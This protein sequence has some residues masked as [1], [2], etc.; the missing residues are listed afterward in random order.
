MRGFRAFYYCVDELPKLRTARR[1]QRQSDH[2]WERASEA[3]RE[4]EAVMILQ[5]GGFFDPVQTIREFMELHRPFVPALVLLE[6]IP[7]R[8]RSYQEVTD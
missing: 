5:L 8:N 2:I 6:K 7:L 3:G 1:R 4:L